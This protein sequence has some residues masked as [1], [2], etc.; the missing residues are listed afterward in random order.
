VRG[1]GHFD[2]HIPESTFLAIEK[3]LA[4]EFQNMCA[5]TLANCTSIMS[6]SKNNVSE[7]YMTQVEA[8]VV[9]RLDSFQPRQ[10]CRVILGFV[11]QDHVPSEEFFRKLEATV[12]GSLD[13][14]SVEDLA[15]L[16]KEYSSFARADSYSFVDTIRARLESLES[17]SQ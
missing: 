2:H 4:S 6:Q 7:E 9:S 8:T 10:I 12:L 1:T 5:N 14:Y 11:R 3:A 15:V 17:A 13:A 16:N